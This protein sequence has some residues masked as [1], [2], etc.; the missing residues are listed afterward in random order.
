MNQR[1]RI[2]TKSRDRRSAWVAV[3]L[4]AAAVVAI[5]AG[6]RW[7]RQPRFVWRVTD[8]VEPAGVLA[9]T[10]NIHVGATQRGGLFNVA[11]GSEIE[12]QLGDALRC[13]LVGAAEV[14]I[15]D[16]PARLFSGEIQ[17][18]VRAGELYGTTRPGSLDLP[19]RVVGRDAEA[20]IQGATFAVMV[21]PDF[22]SVSLWEGSVLIASRLDKPKPRQRLAAATK[23]LVYADGTF[24]D[25][26]A[27]DPVERAQL[28]SV[29]D[30]GVP[31]LPAAQK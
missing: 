26:L 24:G 3:V 9:A 16:P 4:L 12:L 27:L 10:G 8:V 1:E 13:R 28:Q 11:P 29:A 18:I 5:G 20:E 19:L 23:I 31:P 25:T 22:T 15:P 7:V 21:A 17:V 30:G 6:W 14:E 2:V